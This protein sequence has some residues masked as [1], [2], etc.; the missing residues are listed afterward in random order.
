M[1]ENK[2]VMVVDATALEL[3]TRAELDMQVATAKKY[4]RDLQAFSQKLN[5]WLTN[6]KELAS[7][8]FYRLERRS[9]GGQ[10]KVIEGPSVRLAELAMHLFGNARAGARVVDD[11]GTAL[12]C[13]GVAIDL[14]NNVAVSVEV[15]RGI[16]SRE[17]NRYSQDMVNVTANAGCSIAFRNAVFKVVPGVLIQEA[18]ET[19][20][21]VAGGK[22]KDVPARFKEAVERFASEFKVD[23]KDLLAYLGK[24]EDALVPNDIVTLLGLYNALVDGDTTLAEAFQKGKP[25]VEEPQPKQEPTQQ[26]NRALEGQTAQPEADGTISMAE[27]KAIDNVM[28]SLRLKVE[29]VKGLLVKKYGLSSVAQ[30]RRSQYQGFLADLRALA[31]MR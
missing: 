25:P 14:E 27:L 31:N 15:R 22:M 29:N 18:Y 4:P 11:T 21:K 28:A 12:V 16:T 30:L 26:E 3:V 1:A 6:R 24:Q 10:V 19:A 8:C 7:K 9:A 5:A 23:K 13:Q 20:K 17:G 2:D